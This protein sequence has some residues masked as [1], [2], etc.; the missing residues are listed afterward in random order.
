VQAPV[1][2]FEMPRA[3]GAGLLQISVARP[4]GTEDRSDVPLLVVTDAD[5]FFGLAAEI[6]RIRSANGALPSP[7]VVGI[8]YGAAFGEFVKLRTP[9]LTPPARA[10][11][12]AALGEFTAYIGEQSGNAA[13]FADFVVDRLLPEITRRCPETSHGRRLI[14]GHSLGG[15]FVAY[16]LLTRPA[17]FT[18]FLMSSPSLWWDGFAI[19]DRLGDFA[20]RLPGLSAA[21]GIFIGVG[22]KEQDVPT[23]VPP[24]IA[25][26]LPALQ[27]IVAM[28]RM[29]D[30]ATEFAE[31]LRALGV[32]TVESAVFDREDHTSVVPAALSRALTF[33]IPE[34]VAGPGS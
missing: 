24:G 15:L 9:D 29:V 33:A 17:A 22:A 13:D 26:D 28:A 1:E 12:V 2:Q 30:G 21:P 34:P 8:G 10:E 19:H 4:A 5:L 3:R 32:D 16:L 14:F 20:A 11:S 27:G 6:A 18:H 25:M 7:V 23:R 31:K